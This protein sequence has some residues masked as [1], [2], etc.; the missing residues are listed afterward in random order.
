MKLSRSFLRALNVR[1]DEWW[2]VQKLFLLQFFQGAGIAFFF[3]ASFSRFL[4]HFPVTDLAYVFVLSSFLLW[5]AGFFYGKLEHKVSAARLSVIITCVLASSMVLFRAG[6]EFITD[7]WFYFLMLAWF[8]VLYLLNNLMF[9]GMASQLYDV[10]Q[11]KRL[12]SVIS[13]GDMPAKFY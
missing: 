12:F 10:R 3:T 11:S 6:A 4:E 1:R 8:Y 7:N 13:A 5:G 2:L 9:W